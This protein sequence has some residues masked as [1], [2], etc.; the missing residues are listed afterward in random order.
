MINAKPIPLETLVNKV[1]KELVLNRATKPFCQHGR[2]EEIEGFQ[3]TGQSVK[4]KKF[5]SSVYGIITVSPKLN[6]FSLSEKITH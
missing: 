4:R 1:L 3:S 5:K 6:C 2:A